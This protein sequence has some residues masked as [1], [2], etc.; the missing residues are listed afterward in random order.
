MA[1][2]L[3]HHGNPIARPSE[4]RPMSVHRAEMR[5]R[6]DAAQDSEHSSRHWANSDGLSADAANNAAVRRK[7]RN[8]SRYEAI[9][10]NSYA[11]GIVLTLANDVIGTGPR[12]QMLTPNAG[13]NRRIET[14]FQK[15]ASRIRLGQ[16]LR[17]MRLAKCVD[18][19]AFAIL[20]S[21]PA[22]GEVQLDL[23]MVEADQVSTPDLA[24]LAEYAIDGIQFDK[25]W[26]PLEYHV[27][28]DHPGTD[29]PLALLDYERVPAANVLHW[30]RCDRP[31]QHRGIPEI[32]PALPLFAQLRRFTL[33]TIAAA[34]T[35]ASFAAVLQSDSVPDEGPD[36]VDVLDAI[37]LEYRMATTLPK[38]WKLSQV[39]AEHP[40]T[41]YAMFKAEILNE[42]ARCINMPF[43]I[44]AGNSSGY[45]YSSGRLDHQTYYR[46]QRIDRSECEEVCL[47]AIFA[48]WIDEA[49]LA[50]VLPSADEITSLDH[51][52]F[53]DGQEHVDPQKEANAQ[54]IRLSNLTTTLA[55]EHAKAGKDWET[56]LRQIA[57][58]RR[59]MEELGIAPSRPIDTAEEAGSEADQE[60]DQ[61]DQQ[62]V[63]AI[64]ATRAK[65]Q[66]RRERRKANAFIRANTVPAE[67][68]ILEATGDC[69]YKIEAAEDGEESKLRKFSMTAYTGGKMSLAGWPYPV[70][71]DLSGVK[72]TAKS[73]PI[74]RDHNPAQIVG[75]TTE[76]TTANSI[77]LKGLISAAN[78][79]AR[80]IQQSSDNGFPWQASIGASPDKVVYVDRGE[81]VAVNG[82]SFTGPLYVARQS[83]LREVS[84]VALGA[85]DN[86]SSH[87]EGGNPPSTVEVTAM[88]FE[89]W[90]QA[91]GFDLAQIS[92]AQK[93]S[94]KAM[95]DA[96]IAANNT[97]T[98]NE[99]SPQEPEQRTNP[100][101]SD[102]LKTL[103]G[104]RKERQ[105]VDAINAIA[106]Q[107][108]KDHP[109]QFETIEQL[110]NAAHKD[111]GTDER[112]FE[113][114]LLRALRP[115]GPRTASGQDGIGNKVIV[116]A[117]CKS[118]N[119]RSMEAQFDERTL[120]AT[121]RYFKHGI[122]LQQILFRAAAA[123]GQHFD[124]AANLRG[125]LQAAFCSNQY[126]PIQGS[127]FSSID[128]T[129][130][131]SD[132]MNKL[133]VD[134]FNSA[135]GT[136]RL[137]A[138][139]R[140]VRDFRTINSYSLT[141]DLQYDEVGP[142]GEIKHGKLSQESYT[143][144]ADTYAKML[145]ITRQDI[146]ND[147]LGAFQKIPMRLGRGAALKINDVFWTAFL[148]NSTFFASGNSNVSTGG[149]SA[150]DATGAAINAAEIV[151]KNQTDPDGKPLGIMPR[152]MLVPPTLFNTATRLMGSQLTTGGSSNVADA[153]VYQGRYRVAT[154]AY[155]EN[156][157]YTGYSTA[158]WYLLADP[159][160][161]PVIE[162]VFLNGRDVPFV[163][164]ADA[165]FDTLGIQVR[166]YHDFGVALQEPRGGVRSA[167]S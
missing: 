132:T 37:E 121:D 4:R 40:T 15:W 135:E 150:L 123:N 34:E 41:T 118:L 143:N 35:S 71:V 14:A 31:G 95:Y 2:I 86:T 87:L 155:M 117:I 1:Q 7:L 72:V 154:S 151:F 89:Q 69:D 77:K 166:G 152:I 82:K 61:E 167:G 157:S 30:F 59:L 22:V 91:K 29:R 85:D 32:T 140:P 158:A 67:M 145:A 99:P 130:I 124:S 36:D 162:V 125:L 45:N 126:G 65:K 43:N 110:V 19:E 28:K 64:M 47:D 66:T 90:L 92:D 97:Q 161:M 144:K 106:T 83:T 88:G 53:W 46:S 146:I 25:N 113:L 103:E 42:I 137:I 76:I 104:E 63:Q 17:T 98:P 80:E 147:D 136:W 96:E 24:Y 74:L 48:A 115:I 27:L 20:T 133:L 26:N 68:R 165:D 55:E 119:L 62:E 153:N 11:K 111:T 33:A 39:K 73:R 102:F 56:Q 122:G 148:N 78:E 52:W 16:K 149:G 18:G 94:L 81:K 23:R 50:G 128:L 129:G 84:F 100:H 164:S 9:E 107:A 75:H 13:V 163:E 101:G 138:A 10:S 116:A 134:Y 131:L 142:G 70:V 58:E 79:H 105:R 112:T 12:L 49:A 38:G 109:T 8:R 6:Y 21:N 156:S 54:A 57:K 5:G 120:D 93:T 141:G 51:Q 127:G 159:M 3:D 108:I 114:N 44:A 60:D 139:T 160:D